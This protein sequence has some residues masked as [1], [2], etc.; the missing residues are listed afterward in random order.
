MLEYFDTYFES[1]TEALTV[2]LQNNKVLAPNKQVEARQICYY[3][4][5]KIMHTPANCIHVPFESFIEYFTNTK[6]RFPSEFKTSQNIQAKIK[7]VEKNI[8]N[9]I[10][11]LKS[12]IKKLQPNFHDKK[13]RI[14][15]F[16]CRETV[17][18]KHM[19][20]SILEAADTLGYETFVHTQSDDLES[21]SQR[22]YLEA[23]YNV[24]PHITVNINHLNNDFLNEN[25]YNIVWFQDYMPILI[26]DKKVILRNRDKVLYLTNDMK[27]V[28]D[29][30]GIDADYQPFCINNKIFKKRNYIE[31]KNKIIVIGSSY[32]SDFDKIENTIKYKVS[33]EIF[34][35]YISIGYTSRINFK[36]FEV[37][38]A[39][40][41]Y[42][43]SYIYAYVERDLLLQYILEMNLDIEIEL[44]GRNWNYEDIFKKY[45]KGPLKYGEDISKAYNSAKYTLVLGEY[46]LQ[47]RTLEAAASGTIPLVFDVR[48]D[49]KNSDGKCFKESLEFFKVPNELR[50]ILKTNNK[51]DLDCIVNSNS[52]ENF[53]ESNINK[54]LAQD[55]IL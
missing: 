32:K 12:A 49:E 34:Q 14:F 54:V 5:E 41:Y 24:N 16:A 28:L 38:Y 29:K 27:Y 53:I 21:C 39:I 13:L 35:S 22:F 45:Y 44:Y 10:E 3:D 30:K 55:A 20:K 48:A 2:A 25:I 11:K 37:L 51:K 15:A 42:D 18:I 50:T 52:Y 19:I 47:Q 46:V 7:I 4:G 33:K 9:K 6:N 36:H 26:D 40:S 1:P 23:L 43:L 17:L 31:R 8:A